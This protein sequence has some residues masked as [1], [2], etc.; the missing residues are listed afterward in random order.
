MPA[1]PSSSALSANQFAAV[2]NIY[3]EPLLF[4]TDDLAT[5]HTASAQDGCIQF[6]MEYAMNTFDYVLVPILSTSV[7][8]PMSSPEPH[9][10]THLCRQYFHDHMHRVL[11]THPPV[12]TIS[13]LFSIIKSIT[14]AL[15]K[16]SEIQ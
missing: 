14:A 6:P 11:L 4:R 16:L 2:E 9:V 12:V 8:Y 5:T 10:F 7:N 15:P 13:T 3:Q 1:I